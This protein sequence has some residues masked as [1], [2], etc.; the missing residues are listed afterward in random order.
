MR[1][2]CDLLLCCREVEKLL[3]KHRACLVLA[4][5]PR[6][7]NF[8]EGD[9]MHTVNYIIKLLDEFLRSNNRYTLCFFIGLCPEIIFFPFPFSFKDY[10]SHYSFK[11][12]EAQRVFRSALEIEQMHNLHW[13]RMKVLLKIET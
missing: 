2:L 8:G 1:A 12:F 3:V 11:F 5:A 4:N 10:I 6:F 9:T 7:L 13:E